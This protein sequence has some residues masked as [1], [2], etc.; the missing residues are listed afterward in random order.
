MCNPVELVELELQQLGEQLLPQ[1]LNPYE[2]VMK[3]TVK[4]RV[5][6]SPHNLLCNSDIAQRRYSE[7][8]CFSIPFRDMDSFLVGW[9]YKF[10]LFQPEVHS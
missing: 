2:I 9:A 1:G 3:L 8:S 7:R 5:Y 4:N 10:P 6:Q